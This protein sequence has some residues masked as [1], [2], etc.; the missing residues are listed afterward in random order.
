MTETA[1][2]VAEPVVL[3]CIGAHKA[4]TTSL[5]GHLRHHPDCHFRG[6]KELGFFARNRKAPGARTYFDRRIARIS[7]ELNVATQPRPQLRKRLK[8][9][10]AARELIVDGDADAFRDYLFDG[11]QPGQV[12]ADFS[13][14]YSTKDRNV[15]A[16]MRD[17]HTD[18]RFIFIMRDPV[19]RAW[20]NARHLA[21]VRDGISDPDL[22]LEG[23]CQNLEKLLGDED[24]AFALRS[25]YARTLMELNAVIEADKL[26]VFFFEEMFS[27]DEAHK[28][29][30]YEFLSIS[31]FDRDLPIANRGIDVSMPDELRVRTR[32]KLAP[33]YEYVRETFGR[34]PDGWAA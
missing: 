4:G 9:T 27:N 6:V 17:L 23:A 29:T 16:Q 1:P 26:A 21:R 13:P 18:V 14:G 19:E 8:D 10:I 7:S 31:P 28:N 2:Q 3:F 32:Q 12:V 20:S 11:A 25:N 30:L 33:Q 15:Y 5:F 24:Q 22:V 34:T